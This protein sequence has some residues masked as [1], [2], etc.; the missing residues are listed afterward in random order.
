[1]RYLKR[2]ATSSLSGQHHRIREGKAFPASE[3]FLHQDA[4]AHDDQLVRQLRSLVH[5]S[6]VI[7][8][9]HPN[10]VTNMM[11]VSACHTP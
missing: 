10:N 2:P 9:A 3:N 11:P 6:A 7:D 8:G 4:G 5:G 1:V